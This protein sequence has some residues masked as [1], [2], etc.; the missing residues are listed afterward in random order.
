MKEGL[1]KLTE[2]PAGKGSRAKEK[3]KGTY[4]QCLG[5][6][7]QLCSFSYTNHRMFTDVE[8]KITPVKK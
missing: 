3:A 1:F 6:F 5:K 4:W 2:K 7:H 8:Y